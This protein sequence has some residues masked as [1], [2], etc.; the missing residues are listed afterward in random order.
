M[1]VIVLLEETQLR[2]FVQ[3]IVTVGDDDQDG[4]TKIV[5]QVDNCVPCNNYSDDMNPQ[6]STTKSSKESLKEV[7]IIASENVWF[8][9]NIARNS[10]WK[11][12]TAQTDCIVEPSAT[13]LENM[14]SE[15]EDTS[16]NRKL[17]LVANAT[18]NSTNESEVF[19]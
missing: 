4:E 6:A 15:K 5:Q 10:T 7:Y 13:E 16:S 11:K 14:F 9:S 18:Q 19:G 1:S 2:F 3:I 8:V 12:R 17:H